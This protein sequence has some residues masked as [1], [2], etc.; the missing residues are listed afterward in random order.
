VRNRSGFHRRT[1]PRSR[2]RFPPRV[3]ILSFGPP[4]RVSC[5]PGRTFGPPRLLSRRRGGGRSQNASPGSPIVGA[6]TSTR[7]GVC[8]GC[9]RASKRVAV[10]SHGWRGPVPRAKVGFTSHGRPGTPLPGSGADCLPR[11]LPP[12]Y[13]LRGRGAG[14]RSPLRLWDR[15]RRRPSSSEDATRIRYGGSAG[16]TP[17][18]SPRFGI[19]NG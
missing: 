15:L 3:M 7:R 12:G 2:E 19:G 5:R 16:I 4:R 9:F 13:G 11:N 18:L 14:R 17:H 6:L 8:H 1:L 10:T